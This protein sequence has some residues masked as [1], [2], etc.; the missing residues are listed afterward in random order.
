MLGKNFLTFLPIQTTIN[1]QDSNHTEKRA[2]QVV[3]SKGL[4]F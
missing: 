2:N 4:A 3:F 1:Q